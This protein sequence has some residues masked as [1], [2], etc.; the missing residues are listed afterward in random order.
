MGSICQ[1][2]MCKNVLDNAAVAAAYIWIIM[3]D[4]KS[5]DN[6]RW[7]NLNYEVIHMSKV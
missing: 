6:Q 5:S 1:T 7:N 3:Y 4:S 2:E